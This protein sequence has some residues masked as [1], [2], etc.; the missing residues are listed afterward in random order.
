MAAIVRGIAPTLLVGR[1]TAG[2][3]RSDQSWQGSVMS[4]LHF[5][6]PRFRA[7]DQS[8]IEVET[9]QSVGMDEDWE[10]ERREMDRHKHIRTESQEYLP[11]SNVTLQ[12]DLEAQPESVGDH[13]GETIGH[14]D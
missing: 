11:P 10:V 4:S 13:R 3:A 9:L 2:R 14:T 5:G 12:D 8:S 1:V 7:R 6:T